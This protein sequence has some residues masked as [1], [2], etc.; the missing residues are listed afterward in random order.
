MMTYNIRSYEPQDGPKLVVLLNNYISEQYNAGC[1][2]PPGTE[3]ALALL[4]TISSIVE[5][6][7]PGAVLVA[8]SPEGL[9]G[10]TTFYMT[11]A[12]PRTR[13]RIAVSF[14]NYV[15]PR[16]RRIGIARAFIHEKEARARALGAT[17][18]STIVRKS[19]TPSLDLVAKLGYNVEELVLTKE[20]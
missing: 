18:M 3:S 12:H 20:L 17:V 7:L 10:F 8:E 4:C 5:G 11:P 1:R 16:A 15:T 2:I 6:K 19:N 14:I 9:L 13:G